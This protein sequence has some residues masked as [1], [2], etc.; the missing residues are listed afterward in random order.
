MKRVKYEKT[1]DYNERM[2]QVPATMKALE[3]IIKQRKKQFEQDIVNY[4]KTV[5]AEVYQEYHQE[6]V[7]YLAQS[8]YEAFEY[9]PDNETK[10]FEIENFGRINLHIPI[11]LAQDF[12][13]NMTGNLEFQD[14]QF[15][16]TKSGWELKKMS[17]YHKYL[18]RSFP[19]DKTKELDYVPPQEIN[20]NVNT[21][22]L[23]L[24]TR[25]YSTEI[26]VD[27]QPSVPTNKI[28]KVEETKP[29]YN[30]ISKVEQT[31]PIANNIPK[32]KETKP[33]YNIEVNL[34]KAKPNP[35]AWA[36]VIGTK[37]YKYK[38]SMPV[39]YALRDAHSVKRYLLSLGFAESH[40]FYREN[41][42]RN[43]F[44]ALFG[45]SEHLGDIHTYAEAEDEEVFIFISGHGVPDTDSKAYFLPHDGL[46]NNLKNTAYSRQLLMGTN[47]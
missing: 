45:D 13:E 46:V 11:G 6:Q 42:T 22:L 32:S 41:A 3:K 10:P 9:D 28:S 16:L 31:K 30:E 12:E 39:D 20:Q 26:D 2:R 7:Q 37:D 38:K 21:K 33:I 14:V 44:I 25:A 24:D 35:K 15:I 29:T 5:A 36:V 18:E 27:I 17:I 47:C 19:Y 43:D 4:Q 40:I 34:P 23:T 8:K 1:S